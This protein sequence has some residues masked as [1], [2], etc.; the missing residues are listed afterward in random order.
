MFN[1]E[2][3]VAEFSSSKEL[4]EHKLAFE[5]IIVRTYFLFLKILNLIIYRKN[6]E[7]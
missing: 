7:K 1:N 6:S 2:D 5:E 4:E 3:T